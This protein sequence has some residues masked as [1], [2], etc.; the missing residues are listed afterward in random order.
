MTLVEL[1]RLIGLPEEAAEG[2]F[3]F[4][5]R[6]MEGM[7]PLIAALTHP[8][9]AERAE[10]ELEE[11]L[12]GEKWGV[13]ACLLLAAARAHEEYVRLGIPEKVYEDTM[14]CFTRFMKEHRALTGEWGFDRGRWAWRA[15]ALR[16]FRIG[17]LEY[18]LEKG[19]V[20]LHIP[21]DGSLQ[22]EAVRDSLHGARAFLRTYFP[23]YGEAPFWCSSWLLHP[24]LRE[25]LNEKSNIDV[26][27]VDNEDLSY[28]AFVFRRPDGN[29]FDYPEET[30]L[31]RRLK[32]YLLAGGR[33]GSASGVLREEM[34]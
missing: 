7:E 33:F 16:L 5:E 28:R 10:R 18:E 21:S 1:L 3:A 27:R 14:R 30:A 24:A 34:I 19:R 20:S 29:V 2:V 23:A 6:G 13:L 12:R 22:K 32:Q 31:R 25:L 8:L 15:T 26:Q 9:S 4:A 11:W 17:A